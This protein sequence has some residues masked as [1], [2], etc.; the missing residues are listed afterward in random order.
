MLRKTPLQRGGRVKPVNPKRKAKAFE[1]AYHSKAFLAWVHR[2]PCWACGYHGPTPRQAAHTTTGGMGR[3][4]DAST[5]IALCVVCHA[6]QHQGGWLKI[7]MTR[8]SAA[9]AA[10]H[11]WDN[12][13]KRRAEEAADD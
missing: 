8:D 10:Q 3:K 7:G 13:E 1:R 2:L 9:K 11:T 4:A 5:I 6:K 12:W